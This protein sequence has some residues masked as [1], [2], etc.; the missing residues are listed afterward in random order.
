M[1]NKYFTTAD[2]NKFTSHTLD[3]K[4]I[5]KKFVNEF[6]INKKIKT[7]AKVKAEEVE[8]VKLQT[9]DLSL[10]IGQSYFNSD[11]AQLY[12]IIQP[13]YKTVTTFYGL[14]YPIS[15]WEPKGLS[16]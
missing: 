16:N 2:Y 6:D 7:K 4:T 11:G 9:Y 8:I 12:L 3:A 13:I 15:E 14:I 10:F 1:E 5:Q